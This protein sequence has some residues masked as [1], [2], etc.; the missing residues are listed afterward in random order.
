MAVSTIYCW[1]LG[2][3]VCQKMYEYMCI[4]V[5]L[6]SYFLTF[7]PIKHNTVHPRGTLQWWGISLSK[8]R[9][10][11]FLPVQACLKETVSSWFLIKKHFLWNKKWFYERLGVPD[12]LFFYTNTKVVFTHAAALHSNKK[13]HSNSTVMCKQTAEI[14]WLVMCKQTAEISWIVM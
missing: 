7:Q 3:V 9:L 11:L 5:R 13:N 10:L 1:T 4:V 12:N 14:G 8:R 2:A 6:N